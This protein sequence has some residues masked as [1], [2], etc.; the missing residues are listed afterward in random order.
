MSTQAQKLNHIVTFLI[1]AAI[2][3]WIGIILFGFYAIINHFD[4]LLTVISFGL[5]VLTAPFNVISIEQKTVIKHLQRS[6]QLVILIVVI[7][8]LLI[9]FVYSI[10]AYRSNHAESLVVVRHNQLLQVLSHPPYANVEITLVSSS[11][12]N[13]NISLNLS[14]VNHGKNACTDVKFHTLDLININSSGPPSKPTSSI[15]QS[16]TLLPNVPESQSVQFQ[17]PSGAGSQY[18]LT[19]RLDV[20]GCATPHDRSPNRYANYQVEFSVT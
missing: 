16:W 7:L 8:S 4:A 12:S 15:D 13:Q 20:G 19:L 11:L 9:P 6:W 17:I 18:T 2:L 3:L 1:W 5:A 10:I 14:F